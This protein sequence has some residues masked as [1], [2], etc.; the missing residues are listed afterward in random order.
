MGNDYNNSYI[1]FWVKLFLNTFL[2]REVLYM[3]LHASIN[4]L[5]QANFLKHIH[6]FF[7][8][9][10]LLLFESFFPC[11]SHYKELLLYN[12]S[13]YLKFIVI[14]V[15]PTEMSQNISLPWGQLIIIPYMLYI[16]FSFS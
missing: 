3:L 5:L 15:F 7:P 2:I 14:G 6:T 12:C 1:F 4:C 8:A 10:K 11:L 16:L 9:W 13:S